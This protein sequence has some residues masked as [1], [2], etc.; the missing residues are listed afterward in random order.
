MPAIA[1]VPKKTPRLADELPM[2]LL[3]AEDNLVNQ[4]VA[5]LILNGLGYTVRLAANGQEALDA[6]LQAIGEGQPMDAILMDVQMPVL[7]GLAASRELCSQYP[8]AVRPW[9]MAMTAN[10]LE[11]DREI[12]LAAG[13]DDY[14]SKPVRASALVEGLRA[15]AAGLAKRRLS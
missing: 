5:T 12:C 10:A 13:M 11:G 7:D 14:I 6:V 9:I 15:A 1:A 8:I 4:R 3:L 2:R